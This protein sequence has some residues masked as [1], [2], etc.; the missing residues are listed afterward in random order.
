ME[1]FSEIPLLDFQF[2]FNG[3]PQRI[4]LRLPIFVNKFFS[5]TEMAA[6]DFFARW[7]QLGGPQEKQSVFNAKFPID[8]DATRAKLS[9]FGPA[10]LSNVDPNPDNFVFVGIL[11][12]TAAQI[13]CLARLEPNIEAKMYRLTIRASKES[14]SSVLS[15]L[16]VDHF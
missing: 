2:S 8:S 12:T 15:S 13:G 9:G 6:Q 4:T 3:A 14:V 10:L 16:L 7:K 5:P 1:E 11:H